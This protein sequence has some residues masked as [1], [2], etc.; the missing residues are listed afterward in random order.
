MSDI[1]IKAIAL[2][3]KVHAGQFDK[4]GKP[5]ILHPLRLMLKFNNEEEMIIAVL[6]DVIEDGEVTLEQLHELG[7]S[8]QIITAIDCLTRRKGE[9]YEEFITRIKPNNLARKVKIED[10]KD[11]MDLTRLATVSEKDLLRIAKYH[12]ALRVLQ[13]V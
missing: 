2:A 11:N 5:Y 4:A 3:N 6:H 9:S 8:Q 12:K 10:L 1:L 13:G 7:I